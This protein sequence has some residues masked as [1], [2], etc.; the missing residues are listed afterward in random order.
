MADGFFYP[1]MG[2]DQSQFNTLL[3]LGALTPEE[4]QLMRKQAM[5]QNLRQSSMEPLAARSAGNVVVAPSWAEGLSKLGQAYIARKGF[6]KSGEAAKDIYGRKSEIL[7]K[8]QSG[9]GGMGE[10]VSGGTP[11]MRAR[12]KMQM[13]MPLTEEEK[14]AL[15][16]GGGGQI[17]EIVMA[18]I[19]FPMGNENNLLEEIKKYLSAQPVNQV[20]SP[21]V[22]NQAANL[23]PKN[24][25]AIV[26]RSLSPSGM[27]YLQRALTLTEQ[28]PDTAALQEYAK[29]RQ[30][31]GQQSM[32]N[33][34]AAGIAGP[35]YQGLQ[36][37]YLRRAM[38]AQEPEQVG[39]GMAYGGKY[40]A[41]PYA[42]KKEQVATLSNIGKTMIEAETEAEKTAAT[43]KRIEAMYGDNRVTPG[44]RQQ[45]GKRLLQYGEKAD[46]AR[47]A[48][49]AIPTMEKAIK[50]APE[51]LFGPLIANTAKFASA[52][53]I[54]KADKIA[55]GSQL[56]DAVSK[57]FGIAKLSDIGGN[58]TDRELMTAIATTYNGTNLR[59]VNQ[60]L[61]ELFKDVSQRNITKFNEAQ[62]WSNTYGSIL[63]PGTNDQTFDEFFENKFTGASPQDSAPA[64]NR[65]VVD[66]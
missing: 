45:S 44:E 61:L 47:Q 57:Q 32:L 59:E 65:V 29:A 35:Q 41:D 11:A 42:G 21:T 27:S 54:S 34:L 30:A 1:G 5:I 2:F 16:M 38:A 14:M 7:K 56:A 20:V 24:N 13:G 50:D 33:A 9:L 26:P 55:A 49:T 22:V 52:I 8:A 19:D 62:R 6:E 4:E 66:Y 12:Y 3:Q 18:M 28:Q 60:K 10:S 58:D 40:I 15:G 46:A 25:T 64:K 43:E 36:Q 53:G 17:Q 23:I 48:M 51:G 37:G 31:Q 63:R 39:P